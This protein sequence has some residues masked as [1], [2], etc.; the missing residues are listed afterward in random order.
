[1]TYHFPAPEHYPTDEEKRHEILKY[2][3][4]GCW[5]ADSIHKEES[6]RQIVYEHDHVAFFVEKNPYFD[7]PDAEIINELVREGLLAVHVEPWIAVGRRI[8]IMI[9]GTF[10]SRISAS[11]TTRHVVIKRQR[12]QSA[13]KECW[14]HGSHGLSERLRKSGPPAHC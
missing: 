12:L 7:Y 10:A 4:D 3:S 8:L 5:L 6:N 9:C 14:V 1:M 13:R 2:L 11:N